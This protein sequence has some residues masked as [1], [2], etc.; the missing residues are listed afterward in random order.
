MAIP[1][2]V[3]LAD[4][5]ESGLANIVRQYLEQ[6]IDESEQRRARGGWGSQ[7]DGGL[8]SK[9]QYRNRSLT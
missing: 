5:A 6:N 8:E 4:G 7:Q 1:V 2:P 9:G 3:R